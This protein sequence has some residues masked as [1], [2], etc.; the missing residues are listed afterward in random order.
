MAAFQWGRK[1][2]FRRLSTD[3]VRGGLGPFGTIFAVA[4]LPLVCAGG[5]YS[6]VSLIIGA[7]VFFALSLCLFYWAVRS[8]DQIPPGI[9]FTPGPP[10][11]LVTVGAYRVARHPF[12]LAYLLFWAG[13]AIVAPFG[14]GLPILIVMIILYSRAAASEEIDIMKS[15]LAESYSEYRKRVGMFFP[16]GP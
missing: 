11:I 7:I 12:Y 3:R 10:E 15:P 6:N 14:L 4:Q 2:Y 5:L 8:H 1:A 13:A 16:W 9:A